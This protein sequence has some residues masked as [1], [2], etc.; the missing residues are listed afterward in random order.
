M[1]LPAAPPLG[2]GGGGG[3]GTGNATADVLLMRDDGNDTL[4]LRR[5]PRDSS[6]TPGAAVDTQLDGSTAYAVT[7]SPIPVTT[8]P[9]GPVG[10]VVVTSVGNLGNHT[11]TAGR[12]SVTY[13]VEAAGVTL[14]GVALPANSAHT[15]EIPGGTLAALAFVT[16]ASGLVTVIEE[17]I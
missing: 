11:T 4:F 9:R 12:S 3:G 13:F 6:G 5:L 2:Y 17:G 7:G 15:L 10:S 14:D 16:D 8:L 1:T